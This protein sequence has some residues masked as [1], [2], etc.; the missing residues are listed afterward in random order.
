MENTPQSSVKHAVKRSN[1][2]L[3]DFKSQCFYC[4]KPY[5]EDKK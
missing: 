5:I 3:L 2:G 4:E 1:P